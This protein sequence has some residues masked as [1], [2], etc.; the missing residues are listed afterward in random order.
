MFSRRR[1]RPP[2]PPGERPPTRGCRRG[3]CAA[4]VLARS[5]ASATAT[6]A[7]TI[8]FFLKEKRREGSAITHPQSDNQIYEV[9]RKLLGR[10][11]LG[12]LQ[13]PYTVIE[14]LPAFVG[15]IRRGMGRFLCRVAVLGPLGPGVVVFA[16]RL[17][18]ELVIHLRERVLLLHPDGAPTYLLGFLAPPNKISV[19][20]VEL[21]GFPERLEILLLYQPVAR[22]V[23]HRDKGRPILTVEHLR[24]AQAHPAAEKVAL[25]SALL[26]VSAEETP[27]RLLGVDKACEDLAARDCVRQVDAVS[28]RLGDTCRLG[29]A[30]P[31]D[32]PVTLKHSEPE[33]SFEV[34][35]R[36]PARVLE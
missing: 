32:V 15:K 3:P 1:S 4:G 20:N 9:D 13:L 14:H 34:R 27:L 18:V 33:G 36:L 19:G 2:P 10:S 25:P 21:W 31:H 26:L 17:A 7:V 23:C 22:L 16:A 6:V 11:S 24:V 12:P 35:Y 5:T 30:V 29:R 28:A 8:F